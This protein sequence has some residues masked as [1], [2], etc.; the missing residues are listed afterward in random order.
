MFTTCTERRL[1]N[2]IQMHPIVPWDKCGDPLTALPLQTQPSL[3]F[4]PLS[5]KMDS[6]HENSTQKGHHCSRW[7]GRGGAFLPRV[8]EVMHRVHLHTTPHCLG[9]HLH[10]LW[11]LA[12]SLGVLQ[13]KH[14]RLLKEQG[15]HSTASGFQML[16][17]QVHCTVDEALEVPG[18]DSAFG[19]CICYKKFPSTKHAN[20]N[21]I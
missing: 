13:R 6:S 4:L 9:R 12:L 1:P 17:V 5:V 7:L 14:D 2:I 19:G 11:D 20:H 3:Q 10:Q 18:K 15:D 16:L 21:W 8:E